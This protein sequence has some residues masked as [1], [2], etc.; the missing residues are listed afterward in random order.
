MAEGINRTLSFEID[1]EK[2]K[3][4]ADALKEYLREVENAY[5]KT[6]NQSEQSSSRMS[7]FF[8]SVKSGA[9]GTTSVLKRVYDSI[10][11][12]KSLLVGGGS[13]A[14]FGYITKGFLD[15]A[16]TM[17]NF[18]TRLF[19]IFKD[20]TLVKNYMDKINKF[21]KETP[22]SLSES[23]DAAIKLQNMGYDGMKKGLLTMLGD[24]A[25][26][27]GKTLNQSVEMYTDFMNGEFERLKEFGFKANKEGGKIVMKFSRDSKEYFM[28]VA[29]SAEGITEMLK[30]GISW[31]GLTD[32]MLLQSKT[33]DGILAQ[34]QGTWQEFQ[35]KTM[36]MGGFDAIK[37]VLEVIKENFDKTF[38]AQNAEKFGSKVSDIIF[39]LA[40]GAIGFGITF[41][42]STDMIAQG[43]SN[44]IEMVA[45][46]RIG[47]A[48]FLVDVEKA[49]SFVGAGASEIGAGKAQGVLAE[50]KSIDA[51]IA[52]T[53]DSQKVEEFKKQQQDLVDSL[54]DNAKQYYSAIRRQ[55][56]ATIEL[57]KATEFRN[58]V[59]AGSSNASRESIKTLESLSSSLAK[60][61]EESNKKMEKNIKK[62]KE[63]I[64]QTKDG[65][66]IPKIGTLNGVTTS[67]ENPLIAKK[68]SGGKKS[69]SENEIDRLKDRVTSVYNDIINDTKQLG[70][71][72]GEELMKFRLE[73]S[74]LAEALSK[75][76]P[77]YSKYYDLILN[78]QKKLDYSKA[79]QEVKDYTSSIQENIL[80]TKMLSDETTKYSYFS[81]EMRDNFTKMGAEGDKARESTIALRK[82]LDAVN[83]AKSFT[84]NSKTGVENVADQFKK[85][86]AAKQYM[87]KDAYSRTKEDL[88][89]RMLDAQVESDKSLQIIKQFADGVE[90]TLSST[91]ERAF[92]GNFENIG[93]SF[94]SLL[95]KMAADLAASAVTDG[96]KNLMGF[97]GKSGGSGGGGSMG[98][99][100]MGMSLFSGFRAYGG[101]MM[102]NQPYI[103]G[104]RGPEIIIPKNVSNAIPSQQSAN[105]NKAASGSTR[106]N[107]ISI[108][109]ASFNGNKKEIKRSA[110]QLSRMISSNLNRS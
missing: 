51:K 10:F 70:L 24:L 76:G 5:K 82:E 22:F 95:N 32:A 39:D 33:F 104:E 36:Q 2:A 80:E 45:K 66:G 41:I 71:K 81:K 13:I 56:L 9:S 87:S 8:S 84:E 79:S 35:N 3:R 1:A 57:Q 110:N 105:Y 38:D 12:I 75:L 106:N 78:A 60:V 47:Y 54:S 6:G 86:E 101:M 29:D 72:S 20:D 34:M 103:A 31:R 109:I 90:G 25:S 65:V 50:V 28:S 77:E 102:P 64:K 69:A 52:G 19:T 4:G 62:E 7:K 49:K 15:T 63:L 42:K 89:R 94:K 74:D 88:D 93:D 16:R 26:A 68:K 53:K 107:N 23:Y 91:F 17:E 14:L 21:A 55:D 85:L 58:S 67:T 44:I 27:S 98:L 18:K 59:V 99:F 61:K 43:I 30:Q 108:N 100:E 73:H 40:D 48:D 97:G 46:L 92:N 83:N 11:N 37:A 96:L